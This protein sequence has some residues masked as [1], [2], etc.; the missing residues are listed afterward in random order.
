MTG[1]FREL[2]MNTEYGMA[3]HW[4]TRE[5]L[6]AGLSDHAIRRKLEAGTL[7]RLSRGIYTRE[8]PDPESA[9][10]ALQHR[11][12]RLIFTGETAAGVYGLSPTIS[13]PARALLPHR[14]RPIRNGT[15]HATPSRKSHHRRIRGID[16]TTPVSV[17]AALAGNHDFWEL[18]KFL[19]RSYDGLRGRGRFATD[20]SQLT[21]AERADAEPLVHRS[22]IGASSRMERMLIVELQKNGLDPVPNFRFGPY[23][24]DI[25]FVSG[26]TLVE[27]DSRRYH[28]PDA[29]RPA[30]DRVFIMDRWKS[31]YAVQRGWALL[32]YTDDCLREIRREVVAQIRSTVD[33]RRNTP[34]LRRHP[35]SVAGLQEKPV[36]EFHPEL[37][38]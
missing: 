10:R 30:N 16:L 23:A 2:R 33:H 21:P 28:E 29:A 27:L 22:I 8:K 32:T 26:T 37:F 38:P 4:T 11:H 36:W 34:G 12:P 31:N 6:A 24:W 7:Y 1:S 13:A 18:V 19:E 20:L 3:E 17:A 5:L 35:R 9:L 25:G 14:S 15:L